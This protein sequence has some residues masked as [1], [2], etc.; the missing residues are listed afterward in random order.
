MK[1]LICPKCNKKQSTG[2]FCLDDGTL[3][4][5]VITAE[6][7]FKEIKSKRPTDTLKRDIRKWLTRIGVQNQDIIIR[8]SSNSAEVEYILNKNKYSF[9]S[10]RQ[11]N[12]QSNLAGVESFLH[13]R[14]LSIEWGIELAEKAFAG[15]EALPDFTIINNPY[16]VLGVKKEDSIDSIRTKFKEFAKKYHPDINK[17]EGSELQFH[18]IKQALDEIEKEKKI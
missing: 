18:R 7:K 16:E 17:N 12:L 4:K 15:Y 14:V 6:I 3:L 13:N 2:K 10:D 9:T 8:C 11:K 1:I 5:E